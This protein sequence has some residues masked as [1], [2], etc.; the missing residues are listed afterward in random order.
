MTFPQGFQNPAQGGWNQVPGGYAPNGQQQ[1]PPQ[2]PPGLQ[3]MQQ[4]SQ[5]NLPPQMGGNPLPQ[6][7]SPLE[8]VPPNMPG[9]RS[10]PRFQQQQQQQMDPR[11]QQ[12]QVQQQA[13][14]GADAGTRLAGPNVPLH[15][16]GRTV[17]EII[18]ML[19][20]VRQTYFQQQQQAP[21]QRPQSGQSQQQNAQPQ[22]AGQQQPGWDWKKPDESVGRIVAQQLDKL[23]TERLQPMLG[24]VAANN[25]VQAANQARQQA[26][27][28][29]GAAR[30]AQLE[31]AIMNFLQSADPQSLTNAETWKA[32]AKFVV[33][34]MAMRG[35]Q[36]PAQQ[37][38]T[39]QGHQA[40]AFVQNG[41]LQIQNPLP[42]LNGFFTEQPNQGQQG[43]QGVQMTQQDMQ[44]AGAMNIPVADYAAW[45]A[46]IAYSNAQAGMR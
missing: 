11:F 45:K 19:E 27:Q 33:G 39:P 2:L 23:F 34:D 29:I 3:A 13:P 43:P 44:M 40:G 5:F 9:Q 38:Q 14:Q 22:D 41:Q 21:A 42:N 20:G 31:P 8:L 24:P 46:G 26:A 36:L 4:N 18:Q 10:D 35:V 17:G 32:A 28:E 37:Q 16:Q 6:S 12:P 15:Y 1:A 7:Q 30:Y 25:M